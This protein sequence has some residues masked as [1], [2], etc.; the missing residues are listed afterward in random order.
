MGKSDSIKAVLFSIV[1]FVG[2]SL[3]FTFILHYPVRAQKYV[4]TEIKSKG[5]NAMEIE[6][7]IKNPEGIY[8]EHFNNVKKLPTFH[9][10][11]DNHVTEAQLHAY[12]KV[13]DHCW[14][15]ITEFKQT[16]IGSINGSMGKLIML[17]GYAST[18]MDLCKIEGLDLAQMTEDEFTWVRD[19][20]FEAALFALNRKLSSGKLPEKEQ[21]DLERTR[22]EICTV[23]GLF[24]DKNPPAYHW[25]KLDLKKLPRRN[26]VLF[27]RLK[28]EVRY[29]YVNFTNVEFDEQDIMKSAQDL[30]E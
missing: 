27:L 13:V 15:R 26:V 4:A 1:C 30:P 5:R 22:Q 24:E 17:N 8:E 11:A 14:Q 12:Y 20:M 21:A 29:R 25:E 9:P 19:R 23:L 18:M 3:L 10:P 2:M 28:N 7:E 16:Y 6:T